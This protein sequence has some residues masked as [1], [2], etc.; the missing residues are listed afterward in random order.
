MKPVGQDIFDDDAARR[1]GA[2][3]TDRDG[4]SGEDA[5]RHVTLV[6]GAG[7]CVGGLRDHQ[8]RGFATGAGGQ[9]YRAQQQADGESV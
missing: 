8:A 1:A 6:V 4:D 9:R 5:G 3:V 7:W 2:G